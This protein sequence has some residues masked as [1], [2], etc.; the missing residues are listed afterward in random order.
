MNEI[1]SGVGAKVVARVYSVMLGW[2]SQKLS[3]YVDKINDKEDDIERY[4]RKVRDLEARI[5]E[6]QEK[7]RLAQ[8]EG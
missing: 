6:E 4:R 8:S 1:F 3:G 5:K 7:E 2:I